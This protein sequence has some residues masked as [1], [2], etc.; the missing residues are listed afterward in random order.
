MEGSWNTQQHA[1]A[2]A[3]AE[4][5]RGPVISAGFG[6]RS[7]T[8]VLTMSYSYTQWPYDVRVHHGRGTV[9]LWT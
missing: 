2:E 8:A 7:C 3:W 6:A 5:G 1:E 9:I 4:A